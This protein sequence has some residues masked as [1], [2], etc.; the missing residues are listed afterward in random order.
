MFIDN[1][2]NSEE[3]EWMLCHKCAHEFVKWVGV[4]MDRKHPHTG[5]DFCTGWTR[6]WFEEQYRLETQYVQD[7]LAKRR[8]AKHGKE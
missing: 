3:Y 4:P 6:E 7:E 2:F 1:I 5:D 8:E